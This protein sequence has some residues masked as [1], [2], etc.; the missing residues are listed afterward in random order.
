MKAAGILILIVGLAMTF[1]TGF[2]YITKEKVVALG[3]LEITKDNEHSVNWKPYIGFA[4]M[5][6][7]GAV[8]IF[9][10]KKPLAV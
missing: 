2:T 9:G 8:L 10:K 4:I 6:I 3:N 7:G 1:Y 5:A